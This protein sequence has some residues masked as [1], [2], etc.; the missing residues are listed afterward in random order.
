MQSEAYVSH[1][2][3][4]TPTTP[5]SLHE[6]SHARFPIPLSTHV[7]PPD[8]KSKAQVSSTVRTRSKYVTDLSATTRTYKTQTDSVDGAITTTR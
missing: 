5:S 7:S 2:S 4:S 8:A 3:D 1:H 6:S